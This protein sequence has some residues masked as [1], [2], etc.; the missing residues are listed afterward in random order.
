M[1]RFDGELQHALHS[2]QTPTLVVQ[3]HRQIAEVTCPVGHQSSPLRLYQK[4]PAPVSG[5]CQVAAVLRPPVDS[6]RR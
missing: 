5:R 4:N 2:G 3:V 6:G 1:E